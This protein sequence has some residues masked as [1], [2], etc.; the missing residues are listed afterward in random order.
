M[1]KEINCSWKIGDK[2]FALSHSDEIMEAE[3]ISINKYQAITFI[4]KTDR[5]RRHIDQ[6]FRTKQE[7][8]D[9]L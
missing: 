4:Y 2:L 6:V 7:L 5:F 3:F 8:L 1:K 9:S